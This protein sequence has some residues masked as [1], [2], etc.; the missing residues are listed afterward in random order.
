MLG[1]DALDGGRALPAAHHAPVRGHVLLLAAAAC[2]VDGGRGRG[3]QAAQR[4]QAVA[5]DQLLVQRELVRAQLPGRPLQQRDR[6]V[7]ALGQSSGTSQS[8]EPHHLAPLQALPEQEVGQHCAGV[9][10]QRGLLVG[11][12]RHHHRGRA[13][14]HQ[15]VA[16]A[17][18]AGGRGL[19]E[20]VQRAV[21]EGAEVAA[22]RL[23]VRHHFLGAEAAAQQRQRVRHVS[24]GAGVAAW[25]DLTVLGHAALVLHLLQEEQG[26][27]PLL[28]V[29]LHRSEHLRG[30]GAPAQREIKIGPTL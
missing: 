25:Q 10:L 20:S 19:N 11:Q 17:V 7:L 18:V 16:Q 21:G 23:R 29:P 8:L 1:A 12:Q 26:A 13:L 6:R 15:A 4:A 24:L 27:V 2:E 14:A 5:G 30:G 28:V 3:Q 9:V 22:Q